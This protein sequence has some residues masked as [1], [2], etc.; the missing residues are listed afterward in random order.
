MLTQSQSYQSVTEFQKLS[1]EFTTETSQF[2][3]TQTYRE[4]LAENPNGFEDIINETQTMFA[5]YP[6][7][8]ASMPC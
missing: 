6:T 2:E 3:L 4:W 8:A 5:L 7:T 1:C